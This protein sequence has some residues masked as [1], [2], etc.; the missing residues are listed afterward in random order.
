MIAALAAEFRPEYLEW[1]IHGEVVAQKQTDPRDKKDGDGM[2]SY[3]ALRGEGRRATLS[4]L[5]AQAA[6]ELTN[7]F[8][9]ILDKRTPRT[10]K[11]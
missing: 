8:F 2:W 11:K 10:P 1:M 6:E 7:A 5:D 3:P 9:E 4:G